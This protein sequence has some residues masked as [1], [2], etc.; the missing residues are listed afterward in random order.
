MKKH[1]LRG[2]LLLQDDHSEMK[3]MLDTMRFG[4]LVLPVAASYI[5]D[6]EQYICKSQ[7][8]LTLEHATRTMMNEYDT[9]IIMSGSDNFYI[10]MKQYL[11]SGQ[12]LFVV[13]LIW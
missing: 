8:S 7:N 12:W 11:S 2:L 6:N 9:E 1:P 4:A 10:W 5:N 13:S 3:N